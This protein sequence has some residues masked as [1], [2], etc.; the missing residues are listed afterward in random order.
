[1][2]RNVTVRQSRAFGVHLS[3]CRDFLVEGVTFEDH[4]RD[5]VHVNG[6][7][8]CGVIRSVRGVTHDDFVA[9][10]AWEWA[11]YAPSYGPIHHLLVEDVAGTPRVSADDASPLPDGTAELRRSP[12]RRPLPTAPSWPATSA[13]ACS[14][15]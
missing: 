13:T 10:N 6:P 12:A 14:A 8:S 2:V 15:T 7:A 4:G 11:N 9:L 3:N 1:V 5:G